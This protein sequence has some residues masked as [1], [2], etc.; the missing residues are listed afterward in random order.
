MIDESILSQT[1]YKYRLYLQIFYISLIQYT[2]KRSYDE[3]SVNNSADNSLQIE[4]DTLATWKIRHLSSPNESEDLGRWPTT[5][6]CNMKIEE[7]KSNLIQFDLIDRF[8]YLLDG[9]KYGFNQGIPPHSLGDLKW[10]CPPNHSS[11]TKVKEKI[12]ANIEKEV[13]AKRMFGPYTKELVYEKIGFFRTSPLGAVENGDG[14]FRPINDFSF[15]RDDTATPSVNSFVDKLDFE[16]TW[17]DFKIVATFFKNLKEDCLIAIF[18][19]EGAYRQIPTHPSQWPYLA[20][21]GFNEDIYID[22]RIAFGGVAGCGSFGGPAD[23]WKCI[24]IERFKLLHIFRWVDDNLCV[25]RASDKT[26]MIDLVRASEELGVKTNST[27]Y[28]EFS[29]QQSFIGFVW[30]ISDHTVSL[31]AT[32]LLK[33]R[34]EIDEF[35]T[36][37]VWKKNEL[38]KL[39]GKLN[40]MTLILPQLKPYLTA[41]FKWLASWSKP[42]ALKA[43]TDVLEDMSFWRDTLTTLSPTRLIPNMVEWNV[44]WVGDASTEYGIGVIVGKHWAQFKWIK[45]WN[46]PLDLPKRSIAWAETVAIRLGLLMVSQ[47]HPVAGRTISALSDNTTTNGVVRTLRSRDFWVNQE[48]K[49]IQTLLVQLDCS[50]RTHYVKSKDNEA[51]ALSRGCAPSKGLSQCLLVDIPS[52]LSTLLVQVIPN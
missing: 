24:M 49:Y 12:L 43:P 8:G 30:N 11:A 6:R 41:N 35:W 51:D 32:K 15:P 23:G 37:L 52:D 26:S 3:S 9:F 25:K 22:T 29:N 16:T 10:Y 36:K 5:V 17:D 20:V 45:G 47:I 2:D 31:S 18:D 42:I 33:R 39:N 14:S 7:W 27:K 38:E 46:T 21:L 28:A 19:W 34:Q 44:G 13:K 48:W 50:V 40:H 1:S 4:T